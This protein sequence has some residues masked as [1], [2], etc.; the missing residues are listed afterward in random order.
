M[1]TLLAAPALQRAFRS[2]AG[3]VAVVA[4]D[5]MKPAIPTW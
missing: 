5:L 2:A 4:A 1:E 3:I